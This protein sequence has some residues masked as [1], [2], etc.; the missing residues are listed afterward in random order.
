MH[1]LQWLAWFASLKSKGATAFTVSFDSKQ[2]V[3]DIDDAAESAFTSAVQ[4]EILKMV[5]PLMRTA[6]TQSVE[7]DIQEL[8]PKITVV[9]QD[10]RREEVQFD[11]ILPQPTA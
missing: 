4:L 3:I 8:P 2:Y 7:F 5:A 9:H 6:G 1:E 10:G 11:K